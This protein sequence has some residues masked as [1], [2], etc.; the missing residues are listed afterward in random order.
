MGGIGQKRKKTGFFCIF[1]MGENEKSK[2]GKT[3]PQARG[4]QR[5]HKKTKK[6]IK[7]RLIYFFNCDILLLVKGTNRTKAT[8]IKRFARLTKP[9]E[10]IATKRPRKHKTKHK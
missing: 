9:R 1:T 3:C 8:K 6:N 5:K 7:K 10:R 4:N 2:G